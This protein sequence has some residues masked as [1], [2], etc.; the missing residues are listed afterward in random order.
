MEASRAVQ[1]DK[2]IKN[3]AE[4]DR[5]IRELSSN[6]TKRFIEER[7]RLANKQSRELE[8][9]KKMQVEQAEK[10]VRDN[11]KVSTLMSLLV[12]RPLLAQFCTYSVIVYEP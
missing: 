2:K 6:N 3:K 5:R 1:N 12:L 8:N 10:L 11:D 9:L 4:K 7:K